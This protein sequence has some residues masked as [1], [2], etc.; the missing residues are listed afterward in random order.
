MADDTLSV[1]KGTLGSLG[2][3]Y[4]ELAV[5]RWFYST[6]FVR[7][8]YPIPVVF[9]TPMDA[10]GNFQQLW[11]AD[12]SPFSYLFN[13]KDSKGTP[14]Y[15]PY[16]STLRYPLISIFRRNWKYRPE[17]SY[18]LH[19]FRHMNWPTVD[20]DVG[21]CE[22]GTVTTSFR[23]N[24][25]DYRFQV[26]HFCMRPDTQAYF[27]ETLMRSFVVGGGTPQTWMTIHFP[28][29]GFQRIRMYIDGDI[30][31]S[32]KEEPEN[33]T[34]M[35]FRTTFTL[36][37]EGYSVDQDVQF[38][39][40]LWNLLL[41]STSESASPGELVAAF[42]EQVRIDLRLGDDNPTL[43]SREN[44]PPDE[45]CQDNLATHGTFPPADIYLSGS[46]QPYAYTHFGFASTNPTDPFFMG[47][48]Q[49]SSGFGIITV[50]SL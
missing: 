3:R 5:Q 2:M 42:D 41:R 20:R 23:P 31:N 14:L 25:W 29:L 50:G 47:G 46:E 30:E 19:Q 33:M 11:K 22:L 12:K 32:T 9:S 18:G 21:R 37:V 45:E 44:V 17:Q 48:I 43:N 38:V 40:A 10:F 34:N 4:H 7:A 6:F 49:Q 27:I 24:A 8:G 13:L 39:P 26:D 15:E 1:R 16:P 28:V 35:E 36:C